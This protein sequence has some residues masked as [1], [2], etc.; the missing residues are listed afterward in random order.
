MNEGTEMEKQTINDLTNGKYD[1][2]DNLSEEEIEEIFQFKYNP[3]SIR[4]ILES[5]VKF[6]CEIVNASQK[7]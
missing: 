4:K 7:P 2:F 5:P 3:E 1:N 6:P